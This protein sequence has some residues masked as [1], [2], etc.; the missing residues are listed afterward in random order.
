VDISVEELARLVGGRVVCGSGA[1]AETGPGAAAVRVTGAASLAEANEGDVTFFGNAKYLPALKATRASCAL[2]PEDFAEPISAIAVL[3]A[4]PSLAFAQVLEKLA[5]PP[6]TFAPGIHPSAV[7]A[8]G[9]S[10]G[11]SVSIQA[12]VVIEPGAII[13][14]GTVIGANAY[15]GHEARVGDGCHIHPNVTIRERCVLGNRVIV[16]SGTVIGS[17]GFGFEFSQGRHVKIPQT[18]IVQIDDDVEIGSN[19]SIDRA[20]FGRTW[21]GEGSKIDNLVQ[22]AHNVVVGKHSLI[23]SQAGISGSTQIGNYVTIAGQVGTVGHIKIGDQSV[24]AAKSGI[25]KD[26]PP[27]SVVWG[28]PAIPIR[29]EKE[30]IV[31]MSR[32]PKLW[33]KV[34]QLEQLLDSVAKKV[35]NDR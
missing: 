23:I 19:T 27:K 24:I 8:E 28:V 21:I 35:L 13:G 14:A 3:V 16:H 33:E 12:N 26:L 29:E 30:R 22:I 18:G 6:I 7:I 4:N 34:K 1:N 17:D 15:V 2:V 9:V 25:S 11:A 31:Y 5:P 20:R 32:L 10:L